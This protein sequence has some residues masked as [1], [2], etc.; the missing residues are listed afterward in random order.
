M[1]SQLAV[2]MALF[3]LQ[4]GCGAM[5]LS[6]GADDDGDDDDDY[7]GDARVQLDAERLAAGLPCQPAQA[8]LDLDR[9]RCL[10]DQYAFSVTERAARG[11][12]LAR[13]V[14]H[15]L[16]RHLDEAQR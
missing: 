8:P 2:L 12:N 7:G 5:E 14:G 11:Q 16:A 13:P 3:V 15:V 9:G 1:R 4:V 6:P 10:G